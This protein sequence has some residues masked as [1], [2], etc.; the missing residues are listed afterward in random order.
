VNGTEH[1]REAEQLLER[2]NEWLDADSGWRGRLADE[3]LRYRDSDTAQA[4]VHAT[5]ALAAA[6]AP[7][8]SA[9]VP[10]DAAVQS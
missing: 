6:T 1:Y 9:T 10:V 3:R 8:M 7:W 4:Q 2:A 5:L